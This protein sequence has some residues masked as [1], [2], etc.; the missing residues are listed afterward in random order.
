MTSNNGIDT[1]ALV[2]NLYAGKSKLD[3]KAKDAGHLGGVSVFGFGIPNQFLGLDLRTD[4]QVAAQEAPGR[5]EQT[6]NKLLETLNEA[7]DS[8]ASPYPKQQ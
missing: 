1:N 2:S 8:A 3:D 6:M 4:G 7:M 5:W